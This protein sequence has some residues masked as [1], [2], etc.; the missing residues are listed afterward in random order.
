MD[1]AMAVGAENRKVLHP[2][3]SIV[4]N[5]GQWE[6]M[7]NLAVVGGSTAINTA[8]R[9]TAYLAV[10]RCRELFL[11][12]DDRMVAF[13]LKVQHKPTAPFGGCDCVDVNVETG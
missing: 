12:A 7:V 1:N 3:S 10:E 5:L 11:V 9:K 8:E 13:A 2:G 6:Q 4:L